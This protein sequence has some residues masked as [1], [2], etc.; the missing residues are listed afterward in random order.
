MPR[1]EL[2]N[3]LKNPDL[4]E[5]ERPSHTI[6]AYLED[7]LSEEASLNL[8]VHQDFQSANSLAYISACGDARQ[9]ESMAIRAYVDRRIGAGINP[10]KS[11]L[12]FNH[13]RVKFAVIRPHYAGST[14]VPGKTPQGCGGHL[15]VKERR[16]IDRQYE[17]DPLLIY[18]ADRIAHEDPL[19]HGLKL[20]RR[21]A[22]TSSEGKPV[23]LAPYDH[24]T[25]GIKV[26][27]YYQR[28]GNAMLDITPWD[29]HLPLD[30]QYDPKKVYANG[31]P[32]LDRNALPSFITDYLGDYEQTLAQNPIDQFQ[33]GTQD[34]GAFMITTELRDS[35]LWLP[36]TYEKP[37]SGFRLTLYQDQDRRVSP[38]DQNIALA[39]ARYVL[40]HSVANA[41]IPG[42]SF[43]STRT[44]VIFT[45]NYSFSRNFAGRLVQSAQELA[46]EDKMPSWFSLPD[47]RLIIGEINNG[48]IQ[49]I[50]KIDVGVDPDGF[51]RKFD[52]IE[53]KI[54]R[55]N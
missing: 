16:H 49:R 39:Q 48:Q 1:L 47:R 3:S 22:R 41:N 5:Y 37:N 26:V 55:N 25:G 33:Q 21:L 14:A 29:F 36:Q 6:E 32:D 10:E 54:N 11:G 15:A 8:A 4:D 46:G 43:H 40:R 50:G 34:P 19:I 18:A 27:A 7:N 20:A 28:R 45:D 30:G 12:P 52:E 35:A 31:I 17:A 23:I 13:P 51:V 2:D 42:T 24:E 38:D 53:T 44:A 9:Q